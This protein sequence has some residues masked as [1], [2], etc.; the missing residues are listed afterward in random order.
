[1]GNLSQRYLQ[2]DIYLVV[3][4]LG[5]GPRQENHAVYS[6]VVFSIPAF[7]ACPTSAEVFNL[8]LLGWGLVLA[9]GRG[10]ATVSWHQ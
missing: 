3:T 5:T 10:V 2:H 4:V 1:M 7:S 9:K 8:S 6:I